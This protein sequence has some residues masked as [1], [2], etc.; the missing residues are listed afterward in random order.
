MEILVRRG[1]FYRLGSHVHEIVQNVK[2]RMEE[3]EESCIIRAFSEKKVGDETVSRSQFFGNLYPKTVTGTTLLLRRTP[4]VGSGNDDDILVEDAAEKQRG[5]IRFVSEEEE[6][7]IETYALR[8]TVAGINRTGDGFVVVPFSLEIL[9][10]R[11]VVALV[12]KIVVANP[13]YGVRAVGLVDTPWYDL[14]T[15]KMTVDI[16]C[17]LINFS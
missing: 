2:I 7:E 8:A 10:D 14:L 5:T 17:E 15:Q 3:E 16:L 9:V 6:M 4:E 12:E 11:G 1:P 13:D